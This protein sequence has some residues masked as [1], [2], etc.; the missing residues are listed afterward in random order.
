MAV[1]PDPHFK[2]PG[3]KQTGEAVT[4]IGTKYRML[5]PLHAPFFTTSL[6][7]K[8]GGKTLTLGDDYVITH[9]YMTGMERTGYLCHGAVWITNDKYTNNFTMDYHAIGIAEAT[10]A[11]VTAERELNKDKFP[12]DITC[13][14]EAVVGTVYF[15]PVDVQFDWENWR[16]ELELM[17]AI[18]DIG[19]KIGQLPPIPD[20]YIGNIYAPTFSADIMMNGSRQYVNY[21]NQGGY[22]AKNNGTCMV[23]L[24]S[25]DYLLKNYQVDT[26]YNLAGYA[27][28]V[29]A[30]QWWSN[31]LGYVGSGRGLTLGW[32]STSLVMKFYI[33]IKSVDYILASFAASKAWMGAGFRVQFDRSYDADTVYVKVTAADGTVKMDYKLDLRNPPS[34][35]AAA[36]AADNTL[37]ALHRGVDF[38]NSWYVT[39][40]DSWRHHVFPGMTVPDG[41]DVLT[42]L[43]QYQ[44]IVDKLYRDAPAHAHVPRKDNPHRD[45]WGPI[46]ALE[47]NGIASDA[48]LAYGKTQAQLSDYVNNLLPK[49]SSLANK[50]LRMPT[51]EQAINGT[52]GT[53]PG[54][55]SVTS[56]L[57]PVASSKYMTSSRQY[58]LDQFSVG[59][60]I[61][62]GSQ[63]YRATTG[64]GIAAV[65]S[66]VPNSELD[67]EVTATGVK[68]STGNQAVISSYIRWYE[69]EG[70]NSGKYTEVGVS[71]WGANLTINLSIGSAGVGTVPEVRFLSKSISDQ[72]PDGPFTLNLK[73]K[74]TGNVFVITLTAN[75]TA[76]TV[77]FDLDNMSSELQALENKWHFKAWLTRSVCETFQLSS[78]S[79]GNR[80]A[81]TKVPG[82]DDTVGIGAQFTVDPKAIRFL[83]RN[84]ST[85]NA[86]NNPITFQGGN[87]QLILYPDDRGLL[88]NGK[89]LLDPTTVGPYLPGNEGGGDNLFYGTTTTTV[90]INGNGI[91]SVPFICTFVP[92]TSDDLGL[93]AVRMLANDFGNA[94]N[95]AATPALIAKLDAMFTGKLVAA[96]SYVNDMPLTGSIYIDK[97]N[98]NLNDVQN[99]PDTQLPISTLQQA[100]LDKYAAVGHKHTADAFG[101]TKAT[102]T[103]FGLVQFGLSVDDATLALD[104]SEVI[105]QTSTIVDIETVAKTVDSGASINI[106]RY[107]RPGTESIEN[108]I[109][110]TDW[111]ATVKAN[112][113][114]V[115]LEYDAPLATFN[116]AELFPATHED[117]EFG[118]FV[119]V[120][121]NDAKYLVLE[122]PNTAETETMTKIG[123]IVTSETGIVAVEIHNVTRLGEFRELE[124]HIANDNAHIKRSMTQDEFGF[125]YGAGGPLWSTGIPGL[126]RKEAD[127]RYATASNYRPMSKVALDDKLGKWTFGKTSISVGSYGF[128][129]HTFPMFTNNGI[130]H[131]WLSSEPAADSVFESILGSWHDSK[132]FMNRLSIVFARTAGRITTTGAASAYAG[133]AVNY[134]RA[135]QVLIG[136]EGLAGSGA[137]WDTLNPSVNYTHARQADGI[138]FKG[139]VTVNNNVVDF[140]L[141][142]SSTVMTIKHTL[143]S[144]GQTWTT[145]L[146]TRL[147]PDYI[148]VTRLIN[149][150]HLPIYHGMGGL[151]SADTGVLLNYTNANN[152]IVQNKYYATFLDYALNYSALNRARYYEGNVVDGSK[153]SDMNAYLYN[154]ITGADQPV[155]KAKIPFPVHPYNMMTYDMP[156]AAS[157]TVIIRD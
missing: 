49:L 36:M 67:Y 11:Q 111:M 32:D 147:R 47:L 69:T 44:L 74:R 115:G 104:G 13:Q 131:T 144:S 137:N 27:T 76:N 145:D 7:V 79:S 75:G 41:S 95:L 86:G 116:L 73:G 126:T 99:I 50:L 113:Y 85:V 107:G 53:K 143:R 149:D 114:F 63:T 12:T 139:T 154:Q 89:K 100:E 6:V 142:L 45:T 61:N 8:S 15:P 18:A 92:P 106:I 135:Q 62:E 127:W 136:F 3:N 122:N 96:K 84:S 72:L 29:N 33:T 38:R 151:F 112:K 81:F 35:I 82:I 26:T 48:T 90:T 121:G 65:F 118:V 54:L 129:H 150:T 30:K 155:D 55:T 66:N 17:Q 103:T 16:G 37:A 156:G 98:F 23:Y 24:S 138:L 109:T 25:N 91:Q 153:I 123:T 148:D 132:N 88:W 28:N 51:A 52:F 71:V 152:G 14:W 83:G 58:W 110:Y 141:L 4:P 117:N 42:L 10:P 31:P 133:L 34:E 101:I 120:Q 94:E 68:T 128:I 93:M 43:K 146:S 134:G 21:D 78:Q 1:V 60:V 22:V 157:R 39:R 77:T 64:A 97:T 130:T 2:I 19:T 9:P 40:N 20:P 119:D 125:T 124:D 57:D 80:L 56:E 59:K 102:T 140:E 87:N 105:R 70:S 108:G 46:R 5:F